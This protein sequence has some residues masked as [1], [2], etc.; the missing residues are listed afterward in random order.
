M[1]M[2]FWEGIGLMRKLYQQ[3]VEPVCTCFSMTRTELDVLLFLANNPVFDTARDIVEQRK[4]TKSHVSSSLADLEERGYLERSFQR[5]DRRTA[6]IRLLPAA[7]AAVSAGRQA[8]LRFFTAVFRNLSSEE[9]EAMEK[10]FR[11]ITD[12]V[13]E[14]LREEM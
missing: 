3:S 2:E 10:T 13:R 5:G 6:H 8:Q 14:I 7:E 12:N 1:Q 11:K 4:L 9:A